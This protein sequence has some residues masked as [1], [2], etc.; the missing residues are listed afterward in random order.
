M[1]NIAMEM[2]LSETA[3]LSLEDNQINMRYFTPIRELPLA[4]HPTIAAAHVV[5]ELGLAESKDSIIFHAPNDKITI[6]KNTK[7][8]CITMPSFPLKEIRVPDNFESLIGF[9]PT[10]LFES[11]YDWKIAVSDGEERIHEAHPSFDQLNNHQLGH[12]IITAK[13][14]Q[15]G[16]DFIARCF[17]PLSGVNED[18]VTGSAHCALTPFWAK[19]L[20]KNIMTSKQVSQRP[21][22]LDLELVNDQVKITGNAITIFKGEININHP[23]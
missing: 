16:I 20:N 10:Q 22:I 17:A 14:S 2:N 1:Q 4:G 6:D 11:L 23:F 7:G 5:Y 13:S 21:G 9:Q 18:P 3:F 12:L 15:P 19:A 8:I